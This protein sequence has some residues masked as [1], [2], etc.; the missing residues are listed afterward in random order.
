M[1]VWVANSIRSFENKKAITL[2]RTMTS[3]VIRTSESHHPIGRIMTIIEMLEIKKLS[4]R[5]RRPAPVKTL[6][7]FVGITISFYLSEIIIFVYARQA[8]FC[9]LVK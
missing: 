3:E 7:F 9:F 5:G 1:L 2:Y 4:D 8:L 6:F